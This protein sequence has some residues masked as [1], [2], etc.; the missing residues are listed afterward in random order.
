MERAEYT[1]LHK[2]IGQRGTRRQ[3]VAWSRSRHG[4]AKSQSQRPRHS[5]HQTRLYKTGARRTQPQYQAK[6]QSSDGCS[7]LA[8]FERFSAWAGCALGK[9]LTDS[10]RPMRAQFREATAWTASVLDD[11]RPTSHAR[12][13]LLGSD[14][15]DGHRVGHSW[16]CE[17]FEHSHGMHS[18]THGSSASRWAERRHETT[19]PLHNSPSERLLALNADEQ[20]IMM[21]DQLLERRSKKGTE[22]PRC[23]GKSIPNC[24]RFTN[25]LKV[26]RDA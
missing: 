13:S 22:Q 8:P 20:L 18:R 11:M 1:R 24:G 7:Q 12:R 2:V 14:L 25:T 3:Y 9:A 19:G 6:I 10:S 15:G 16:S 4:W 26:K 17:L 5:R 23:E 21:L